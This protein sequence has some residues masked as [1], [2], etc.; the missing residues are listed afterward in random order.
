[1]SVQRD[2]FVVELV[3]LAGCGKST[4]CHRAAQLLREAGADVFEPSFE[5]AHRR[6]T[7]RRIA[8]KL[9]YA[10]RDALRRPRAAHAAAT[11]ALATRQT[12]STDALST[13]FNLACVRGLLDA[14]ADRPGIHLFDQGFYG[15][16]WSV[17][18]RARSPGD[19]VELAS[20]LGRDLPRAPADLVVFVE[21]APETSLARA[22]ARTLEP[23]GGRSRLEQ[24]GALD[25]AALALDMVREAA[26]G[27]RVASVANDAPEPEPA[28]RILADLVAEANREHRQ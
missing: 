3:G 26:C 21:T 6:N 17:G 1:M 16:L 4:L 7:A 19:P 10:A 8:G 27:S 18:F 22:R 20:R 2:G 11:A 5:L 12:S 24:E 14:L 28:A 25:R 23:D 9:G 13:V 15:A